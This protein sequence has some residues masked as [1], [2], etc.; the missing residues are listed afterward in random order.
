[1]GRAGSAKPRKFLRFGFPTL[2]TRHLGVEEVRHQG[3]LQAS[4]GYQDLVF[5]HPMNSRGERA[6]ERATENREAD[7]G[8]S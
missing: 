1:M 3:R 6:R 8:R 4:R 5:T 7:P 2:P